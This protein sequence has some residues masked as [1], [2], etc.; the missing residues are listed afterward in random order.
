MSSS[1]LGPTKKEIADYLGLSRS[2]V[3]KILNHYT[4][5]R[6]SRDTVEKVEEAARR[7]GYMKAQRR[8]SPRRELSFTARFR[9][10][11]ADGREFS[12]GFG[13]IKDLSANGLLLGIET[14]EGDL[15]PA[16]PHHYLVE[17]QG[18][19]LDGLKYRCRPVRLIHANGEKF[20]NIGLTFD[21]AGRQEQRAL[22]ELFTL[23]E[24]TAE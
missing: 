1:S 17:F 8:G 23:E 2:T 18:G 21:G 22:E 3:S 11:L 13:T 4:R 14:L 6:F 12:A 5:E 24:E 20:L 7:L 16:A 10:I 19:T 15:F 9:I